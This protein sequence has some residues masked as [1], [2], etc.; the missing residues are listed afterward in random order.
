VAGAAADCANSCSGHGECGDD[1]VCNCYANWQSG[2]E[3]NG[4]DCSDRT[5]PFE[6]AWIDRP[7]HSG[8]THRYAECSNRGLCDRSSGVCECF[9]GYTGASCQRTTCPNDCSG[10]GTCEYLA[11]LPF[12]EVVGDYGQLFNASAYNGSMAI[13]PAKYGASHFG[14]HGGQDPVTF[15]D[16]G[17]PVWDQTK[18]RMCVCDAKWTGVDCSRRM[19]PKGNDIT[20]TRPT[21]DRA[22][23]NFYYPAMKPFTMPEGTS[24]AGGISLSA[25]ALTTGKLN[26]LT[27][28]Q[29]GIT[30]SHEIRI[31]T[32]GNGAYDN[33]YQLSTVA[34]SGSDTDLTLASHTPYQVHSAAVSVVVTEGSTGMKILNK[35]TGVFVGMN[36]QLYAADGQRDA[37]IYRITDVGTAGSTPGLNTAAGTDGNIDWEVTV[38]TAYVNVARSSIVKVTTGQKSAI[39]INHVSLNSVSDDNAGTAC[40]FSHTPFVGGSLSL[41]DPL[42]NSGTATTVTLATGAMDTSGTAATL[43]LSDADGGSTSNDITVTWTAENAWDVASTDVQKTFVLTRGSTAAVI[44]GVDSLYSESYAPTYGS[45]DDDGDP[46]IQAGFGVELDCNADSTNEITG[47]SVSSV[48]G[49]TANGLNTAVV[50]DSVNC[51]EVHV[52]TGLSMTLAEGDATFSITGLSATDGANAA[53]GMV[54]VAT[55]GAWA[56]YANTLSP[57]IATV[58]NWDGTTLSGTLSTTTATVN[59][60]GDSVTINDAI[61][62]SSRAS[63]GASI[64]QTCTCAGTSKYNVPAGTSYFLRGSTLT[65]PATA[66]IRYTGNTK[67]TSEGS[68][69]TNPVVYTGLGTTYAPC[70]Q[71]TEATSVTSHYNFFHSH[72]LRYQIQDI[73]LYSGGVFGDGLSAVTRTQEEVNFNQM[74]QAKTIDGAVAAMSS[75]VVS[76]SARAHTFALTFTT[77]LNETYTTAPI[78]LKSGVSGCNGATCGTLDDAGFIA[79]AL[80]ALPNKVIDGVSVTTSTVST[81]SQYYYKISV[82]F[83]GD[84]VQ[85]RQNLLEVEDFMCGDGCTPKRAGLKLVSPDTD[86][87]LHPY[88]EHIETSYVVESTPADWNSYEC[89]RRGRCD[90]DTGLCECFQGYYGEACHKK[91]AIV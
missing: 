3:L 83:T 85:G 84:A 86:N 19:C 52:T 66:V 73:Y 14:N 69:S 50:L 34:T 81:A 4:G 8:H 90:Y 43:T 11:D 23:D 38:H 48:T 49:L 2:D 64:A 78:E 77:N 41:S 6:I 21:S 29:S 54:V 45:F 80:L 56:Q 39:L 82:T 37:T 7:Q 35:Q 65:A 71:C 87:Y 51:P 46:A 27:A 32:D 61:T 16:I 17:I 79:N 62:L 57:T 25:G 10:H 18:S 88:N 70:S 47:V 74:H 68:T 5:C 28:A 72:R 13:H 44:N 59:T 89:G 30:T 24:P 36:I 22:F 20:D 67:M 42:F 12:G 58:T 9:E 53:V 15:K 40:G 26:A 91:S 60:A 1:D 63:S 55:E 76:A 75:G 33:I 31:D